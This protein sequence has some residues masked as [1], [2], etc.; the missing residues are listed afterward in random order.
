MTNTPWMA[1]MLGQLLD[2]VE[3]DPVLQA[4]LRRILAPPITAPPPTAPVEVPEVIWI[5]ELGPTDCGRS[6]APDALRSPAAVASPP[7][8]PAS[9]AHPPRPAIRVLPPP[10][11]RGRPLPDPRSEAP[12]PAAEP[13][14]RP[15]PI[16]P[17]AAKPAPAAAVRPAPAAR[18]RPKAVAIP[19]VLRDLPPPPPP[20][21]LPERPTT[22]APFVVPWL[23]VSAAD[24]EPP[25]GPTRCRLAED[26]R[27]ELGSSPWN[28]ISRLPADLL[29][30]AGLR[31]APSATTRAPALPTDAA[32]PKPT[33][34]HLSPAVPSPQSERQ[35][36]TELLTGR[37][38][39]M[40]GGVCRP[41]K[42]EALCRE[43]GLKELRW[44]GTRAH[45]PLEPL[46]AAVSDPDVDLV[47]LLIRLSSHSFGELAE[48]CKQ[49]GIPL[50]RVPG[51]WGTN[52]LAHQILEQA[53]ER[54]G[55]LPAT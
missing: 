19:A 27:R 33:I 14:R 37:V 50:V 5:G 15:P 29:Q 7:M 12:R 32:Q 47:L 8:P 41:E 17:P 24:A 38:A 22:V 13:P 40:I 9:P 3:A 52:Q 25:G 42:R 20:P 10:P 16:R 18:D 53:G 46:V 23:A 2:A 28:P 6:A 51:G 21:A 11:V 48:P 55:T 30:P 36:V 4:R 45:A 35:R 26:L 34:P 54:L 49:R 43:L 31:P 39:V 1:S 44:I